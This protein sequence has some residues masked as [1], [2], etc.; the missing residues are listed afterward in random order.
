VAL[1]VAG[2]WARTN[3][4][5]DTRWNRFDILADDSTVIG[6]NLL[7]AL[8]ELEGALDGLR[9]HV[10]VKYDERLVEKRRSLDIVQDLRRYSI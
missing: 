9:L 5:R 2:S 7:Y 1:L 3:E 6:G 8:R 4:P 10:I